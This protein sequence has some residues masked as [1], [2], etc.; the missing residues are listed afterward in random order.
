MYTKSDLFA[1]LDALHIPRDRVVLMH[2]SLRLVGQVEGGALAILRRKAQIGYGLRRIP[3]RF[4]RLLAQAQV[5]NPVRHPPVTLHLTR[6]YQ[7]DIIF[8]N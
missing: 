7:Y 3:K 5:Q 8:Q 2:S 6:P 4:P 1:Q